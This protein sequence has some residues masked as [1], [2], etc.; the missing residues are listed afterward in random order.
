MKTRRIP[1]RKVTLYRVE[2]VSGDG[3]RAVPVLLTEAQLE[4][5]NRLPEG[6]T[7]FLLHSGAEVLRCWDGLMVVPSSRKERDSREWLEELWA[8]Q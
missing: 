7:R 1:A 8:M 4:Q 2:L 5:L 3:R 6:K